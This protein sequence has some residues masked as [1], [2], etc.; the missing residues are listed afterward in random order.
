[1]VVKCKGCKKTIRY[2]LSREHKY[3]HPRCFKKMESD[4]ME[5]DKTTE[6]TPTMH[7]SL[8]DAQPKIVASNCIMRAGNF[9]VYFVNENELHISGTTGKDLIIQLL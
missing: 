4:K 2:G 3:Y 8:V 1:M 7:M 9:S 5:E 6:A